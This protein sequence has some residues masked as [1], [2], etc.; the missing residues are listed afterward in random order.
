M[1]TDYRAIAGPVAEGFNNGVHV[2]DTLLSGGFERSDTISHNLSNLGSGKDVGG[3]WL[4]TRDVWSYNLGKVTSGKFKFSDTVF[5]GGPSASHADA[6]T[7]SQMT[8]K[9]ATSIA[10]TIPTNPSFN[11]VTFIGESMSDGIPSVPVIESWR[12]QTKT[13]KASGGEYLN[14]QF[15]WLPLV[16]DIR[17]FAKAVSNHGKILSDLRQ[18]SGKTTRVGYSFPSSVTS[19]SQNFTATLYRGGNSGIS[20]NASAAYNSYKEAKTWFNG[21]FTYHLPVS[22]SQFGKAKLYAEYADK[23]LGVK[24]SPSSIYNAAPWTWA[25]DWFT[26][27]GDIVQN[28]SALGQNG[29]VLQYGYI[30]SSSI[31]HE[32]M[33]HSAGTDFSLGTYTAASKSRKREMK[34]RLQSNPY[35]FGV[36]DSS[37]S[38]AQ[39]AIIAALGLSSFHGGKG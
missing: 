2:A 16:S 19:A 31:T 21:A 29:L 32:T 10:R 14:M 26:N 13:A 12:E 1:G 3:P 27:A 34:K 9:G 15:G 20:A 25:L 30:M 5:S 28:I 24:P 18:G 38:T 33:T 36:T 8:V 22:N 7:D 37:L 23:L 35:G 6:E 4:L 39:K 11:A 17:K